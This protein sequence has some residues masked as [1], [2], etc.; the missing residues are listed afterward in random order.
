[1][2]KSLAELCYIDSAGFHLADYE[3][4]LAFN[5]DAL[6][7]IYG[8]DINLDA[9]SQD[10]QLCAHIAQA[11][12]DL[13]CLCGS[14]FNSYSPSSAIGDALSRQVKINGIARHGATN[15]TVDLVLKGD[16]GTGIIGGQAKDQ[17]DNI[18]L[19]PDVTIPVSGEITVTA[20]AQQ[21]GPISAS[22]GTVTKINTPTAGW[23]SVTNPSEAHAGSDAETDAA[24]R[25]RQTY[26]TALPA[27]SV[28]KGIEGAISNLDGVTRLRVYENDTSETDANGIP[29][30]SISAVVEGGSAEEIAE[31]IRVKKPAGTGTYGSTNITLIDSEGSPITIRFFRPTQVEVHVRITLNPLAGYSSTYGDELR[32]E[33][34]NYINSLSIGA[35]VYLSKVYV[36]ANLVNSDYDNAYDIVSIELGTSAEGVTAGNIATDFVSIPYCEPSFVEIVVNGD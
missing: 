20:T 6:R 26:S 33:V 14:V 5:Q 1:M 9:D 17:A 10:G 25:I 27:Q 36:P 24:L 3:D 31:T 29:S 4:F 13:G 28:V 34:V 22:P 12:Y 2:A 19:I 32:E 11:Q 30:H 7:T 35:T 15:S 18:W 8:Q 23:I 21:A 16:A